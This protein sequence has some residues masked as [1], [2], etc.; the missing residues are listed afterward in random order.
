MALH[1]EPRIQLRSNS[2]QGAGGGGV[3][4]SQQGDDE[5]DRGFS[6]SHSS[7]S[8]MRRGKRKFFCDVSGQKGHERRKL[9]VF[10][11][12]AWH[13]PADSPTVCV[14]RAAVDWLTNAG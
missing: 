4:Q 3:G 7:A 1:E 8:G 6:V 10:V 2:C 11:H 14:V 13:P 9:G 12:A 5:S